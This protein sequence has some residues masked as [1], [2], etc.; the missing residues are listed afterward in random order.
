MSFAA[1]CMDLQI[2]M[3]SKPNKGRMYCLYVESK[4]NNDRNELKYKI[5][6]DPEMQ[7]TNLGLPK[8]KG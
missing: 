4:K 7:K 3:L 5:D 8:G 2:I 1:T 6:V